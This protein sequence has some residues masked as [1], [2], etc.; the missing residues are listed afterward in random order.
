MS[1]GGPLIDS[2]GF[3]RLHRATFL[4]IL[5]PKFAEAALVD[6]PVSF[7]GIADGSRYDHS[8]GAA[9]LLLD[10][11]NNLS[12]SEESC[13]YAVAWG[14][15]HDIATWPLSHT[16]EAAFHQSSSVTVNLTRPDII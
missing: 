3:K 5:S 9:S 14:L 11:C 1:F 15:I 10:I 8:I 6:V 16:G 4:G 7:T 13:R 2:E 12:L